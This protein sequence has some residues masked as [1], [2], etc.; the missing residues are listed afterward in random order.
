MVVAGADTFLNKEE[1]CVCVC[2]CVCMSLLGFDF[3][4]NIHIPKGIFIIR[5]TVFFKIT[6]S[7][8]LFQYILCSVIQSCLTLCGPTDCSSPVSSA[9][10]LF[11]Q[12]HWS[13][14]LLPNPGD[15]SNPGI[16]S[17]SLAYPVLI[18]SLPLAL[19]GKPSVYFRIYQNDKN[20][21]MKLP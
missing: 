4:K 10:G 19:S 15:L 17:V 13:G 5:S 2:M 16:E 14:L 20:A 11:Q 8:I 1:S 12:E 6:L 9:H 7:H 3:S 21:E 18:G